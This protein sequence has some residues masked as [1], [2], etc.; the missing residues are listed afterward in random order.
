MPT[1]RT[2]R[3]PPKYRHF[4]PR[5]L[6]VVRINGRDVYLG[7]FNSPGSLEKYGGRVLAE[8][9]SGK[10]VESI[11]PRSRAIRRNQRQSTR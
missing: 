11:S 10:R 2:E 6:A 9:R 5:G 4:K 1:T 7:P 3:K 8:W